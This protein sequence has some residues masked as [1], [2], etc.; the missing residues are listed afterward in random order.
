MRSDQ[1]LLQSPQMVDSTVIHEC[2][3]ERTKIQRKTLKPV[4]DQQFEFVTREWTPQLVL[5]LSVFDFELIGGDNIIGAAVV[6]IGSA[7]SSRVLCVI[8]RLMRIAW[9]TCP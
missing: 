3:S 6:P 8:G 1:W 9:Q 5:T 4:F 7:C 2:K